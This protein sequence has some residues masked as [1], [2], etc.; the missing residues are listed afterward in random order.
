MLA[1]AAVSAVY[2]AWQQP[3]LTSTRPTEP[4]YPAHQ[5][6]T[7][8]DLDARLWEDPFAAVM[9][10]ID[11]KRLRAPSASGGHAGVG[12]DHHGERTLV[13]GVT[14][15]GA[16]YPEV[17]ETRRRLRYAVLSALH[18]AQF[19]PIDEKHI[20][21]WRPKPDEPASNATQTEVRVIRNDPDAIDVAGSGNGFEADLGIGIAI[22]AAS[23]PQPID[24]PAGDQSPLPTIVP[25]EEFDRG[26]QHVLVLW[27]DE[28][29]LTAGGHPIASLVKLRLQTG[30]PTG[31]PFTLLGPE[32]STMLEA[33]VREAPKPKDA[34][35]SVYNFGA[36]AEEAS[37]LQTIGENESIQK[38]FLKQYSHCCP[39]NKRINSIG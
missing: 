26:H 18:V 38:F 25:W 3:R 8:Q 11:A 23:K 22:R 2:V 5:L 27:L 4:E 17:A 12:Y 6:T 7:R 14:L 24:D 33:M 37:I 1:F 39:V 36:T 21:Y 9:R 28:D 10:D 13:L 34:R 19:T 15:P 29:V 30:Y 35:F 31:S 32:D 20:G 16:S